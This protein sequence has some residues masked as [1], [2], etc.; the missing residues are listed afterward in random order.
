MTMLS[1]RLLLDYAR[2]GVSPGG[3]A[4]EMASL[5]I[6]SVSDEAVEEKWGEA[7]R[8]LGK[9]LKRTDRNH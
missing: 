7:G 5:R 9:R 3:K 6:T 8:Y 4:F 1:D 2:R